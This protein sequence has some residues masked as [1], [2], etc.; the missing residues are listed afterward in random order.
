MRKIIM[1]GFLCMFAVIFASN[2]AEAAG[3]PYTTSV[4]LTCDNSVAQASAINF[5]LCRFANC[6]DFYPNDGLFPNGGITLECGTGLDIRST[7]FRVET[8]FEPT[9]FIVT[10][11]AVDQSGGTCA[12]VPNEGF[13]YTIGEVGSTVTCGDGSR[14]P[15]LSVGRP[16]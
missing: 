11:N 14:S 13:D 12:S 3:A 9:N 1:A 8:D 4:K 2:L 7:G 10:I 6:G 5:Y 16:H 15:K